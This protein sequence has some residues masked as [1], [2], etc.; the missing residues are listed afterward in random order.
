MEEGE[1]IPIDPFGLE[2]KEVLLYYGNGGSPPLYHGDS[3]TFFDLRDKYEGMGY[4]V[5][6]TDI[7]PLDLNDFKVV[8]FIMPGVLND[9]G[10][11]YFTSSQ[12]DDIEDYLMN[13]G[14][15]VVMGEHSGVFGYRTVNNLLQNLGVGIRQFADNVLS[16]IEP[17]ATDITPDP[18]TEGVTAL[19]MDGAG[20]SSL[21]I[22]GT[23]KSLVRDRA[24]RDVVAVDQ[25]P[26]SPPRPG[27]EVL[28]FG[29]TQVLDDHQLR[30][31]DGD[32]P[33]ENFIFA[34]DILEPLI[35]NESPVAVVN[36]VAQTIFEGEDAHLSGYGSYDPD[37]SVDMIFVVDTSPSMP[38]EWAVLSTSLP[39]IK[40]DLLA[41]GYDL[42]FVVYGLD[43]GTETPVKWPVMDEWLDYGARFDMFGSI[44]QD[45][46]RRTTI[47]NPHGH[48]VW[49]SNPSPGLIDPTK[50]C[51][52]YSDHV[53]EGWAQGAAY[54]ALNY[55]WRDGATRIISPIGD[56]S[57][58]HQYIDGSPAAHWRGH[59]NL[60][61]DDWYVTNETSTL[62]N[63]N[64][65]IA[66]PMYDDNIDPDGTGPGIGPQQ[67]LFHLM[68]DNTGGMAFPL[69]DSQGFIDNVKL[70]MESAILDF[71]WDFDASVDLN[72]DG[73]FTNDDEASGMNVSHTF[74][75]DCDCVVTLTVTDAGGLQDQAQ[76]NV[77]VLNVP[78][79]VEWTSRSD[80]GTILVPPYP[81]GKDI[82]F[83]SIVTDPGIYDTFT[84][85]WD[86]GDG[87]IILDG[88]PSVVHAYGD[89]GFYD[90][91]LTVTDD[92]GGRTTS[93][94]A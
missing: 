5:T 43:H 39:Q 55:P 19:D 29:D 47:S 18:L 67:Q 23:A 91:V 6:Y 75:D 62:L 72:L 85:D 13:R 57:P 32:G 3:G 14:R 16:S 59:P 28:V 11:Y 89:N 93:T 64:D 24:G 44:I 52:F 65:V 15:L 70:L 73:D 71:S 38:D 30:D 21:N 66:F 56:A 36:P 60:I 8:F 84:Y 34:D 94:Q 86:L 2:S 49:T 77:T 58:M 1:I 88:P 68:A 4:P 61:N 87:T 78:P 7:W 79:T 37:P 63:V 69:A 27:A 42:D 22:W 10:S 74:Y 81:E 83:E 48:N 25:I 53:S 82:L 54:V 12:V 92:D 46:L 50:R 33:F 26:G 80:D 20:V 17:A 40:A 9:D 76:A 90:V 35:V 41:E 51:D 45:C 31:K